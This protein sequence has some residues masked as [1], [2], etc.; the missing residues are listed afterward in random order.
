MPF[1]AGFPLRRKGR[2]LMHRVELKALRV[3]RGLFWTFQFLM[4][5]VELKAVGE[6]P[7]ISTFVGVV[8]NA[9]C[10]VESLDNIQFSWEEFLRGS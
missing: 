6:P 10:G 9:P 4:H 1:I 8:P 2:F 7:T 3:P 5:R